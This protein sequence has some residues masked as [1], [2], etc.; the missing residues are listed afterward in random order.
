MNLPCLGLAY[1]RSPGHIKALV[2]LQTGAAANYLD[3]LYIREV[4]QMIRTE[5]TPEASRKSGTGLT[6]GIAAGLLVNQFSALPMTRSR[7]ARAAAV[8]QAE[9]ML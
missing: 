9:V 6:R 3:L 7:S 8:P 1:T 4:W 2:E 5:D